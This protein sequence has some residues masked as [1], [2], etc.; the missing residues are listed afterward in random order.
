LAKPRRDAE[1]VTRLCFFDDLFTR[2]RSVDFRKVKSIRV[3]FLC[4]FHELDDI[5]SIIDNVSHCLLGLC[6]Q[7]AGFLIRFVHLSIGSHFVKANSD[8]LGTVF[9]ALK[10]GSRWISSR[11]VRRKYPFRPTFAICKVILDVI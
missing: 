5:A 10:E 8:F 3:L 4:I 6:P 11:A 1:A 9:V 7:I 2:F